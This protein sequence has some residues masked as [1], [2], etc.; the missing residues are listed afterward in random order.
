VIDKTLKEVS[1][2]E[3]IHGQHC[4]GKS[5]SLHGMSSKDPAITALQ[6]LLMYG[7]IGLSMY[8]YKARKM[9]YKDKGI[10]ENIPKFLYLSSKNINFSIEI[11]KNTIYEIA[12]LKNRAENLYKYASKSTMGIVEELT[13]PA[14]WQ[15]ETKLPDL[16]AQGHRICVLKSADFPD[17]EVHGLQEI[18][19]FSLMGT[20][21]YVEQIQKYEQ[22]T[23]EMYSMLYQILGSLYEKGKSVDEYIEL[24]LKSGELNFLAMQ[25]LNQVHHS[26]YGCPE[27]SHVRITPVKGKAILVTGNDYKTLENLLHS[28]E[29]KKIS[30]YTHGEMI[31]AHSYP[32]I[33][34][35]KHLVGYYGGKI[36]DSKQVLENFPGAVLIASNFSRG[37]GEIYRGRVFSTEDIAWPGIFSIDEN[38]LRALVNAAYDSQG[39]LE[40]MEAKFIT[41]GFGEKSIKYYAD[42]IL[43]SFRANR[44]K[45]FIFIGGCDDFGA[46]GDY[47]GE[48]VELMP[49]N[50]IMLTLACD[51]YRF[52]PEEI[53]MFDNLPRVIDLGHYNDAYPAIKMALQLAE[54][55]NMK[56]SELPMSVVI[57][58]N[59]QKAVAA[60]LSL[61]YLGFRNIKLGPVL[62]AYLTPK[63]ID[64]LSEKFKITK[65]TTPK[66]DMDEI[67]RKFAA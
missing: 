44:L 42:K 8:A 63:L 60:L 48:I 25:T 16:I 26:Y 2:M 15:P 21:G 35:H 43:K 28:T 62:P 24:V 5:C 20:A 34:R 54:K 51:K 14:Q 32:E 50:S 7:L 23:E 4:V 45:H 41:V 17:P 33:K 52:S 67:I 59:E 38:D 3:Y 64:L 37:M 65:I 58:W 66:N 57:S 12:E 40:E 18:I 13:G 61:L 46:E 53:G 29:D 10:D 47:M 55:M 11:L 49:Q 1:K 36:S 6:D 19:K 31:S 56:V 30:I 27:P 9:G 22:V 39:F